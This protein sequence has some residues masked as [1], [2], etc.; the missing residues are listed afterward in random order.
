MKRVGILNLS[1]EELSELIELDKEHKIV[2]V[3]VEAKERASSCVLIKIEGKNMWETP[4]KCPALH[5]NLE[6]FKERL[7]GV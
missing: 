2:D 3:I 5:M 6:N 1:Y 7:K 4:P